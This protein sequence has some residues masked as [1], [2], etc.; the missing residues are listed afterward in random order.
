MFNLNISISS[1]SSSVMSMSSR[2]VRRMTW[3]PWD[4]QAAISLFLLLQ[5]HWVFNSRRALQLRP[6]QAWV[7][8]VWIISLKNKNIPV[9]SVGSNSPGQQP[10]PKRIKTAVLAKKLL[11]AA[12]DSNIIDPGGLPSPISVQSE[13]QQR[14]AQEEQ[15]RDGEDQ[16]EDDEEEEEGAAGA[17]QLEDEEE[18]MTAS[19]GGQGTQ[20]QHFTSSGEGPEKRAHSFSSG[21]TVQEQKKVCVAHETNALLFLASSTSY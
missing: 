16:N 14:S 7:N 20:G 13:Q 5:T 2:A 6:S 12:V 1:S 8:S 18:E 10:P 17:A 21:G 3:R 9:I 4:L 19:G 11:A 15:Q